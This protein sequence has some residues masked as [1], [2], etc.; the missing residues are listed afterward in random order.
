MC[1][2]SDRSAS[3]TIAT[4]FQAW[5]IEMRGLELIRSNTPAGLQAMA[6]AFITPFASS[7]WSFLTAA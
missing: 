3:I 1:R 5:N 7:V 2:G 4:S 6:R